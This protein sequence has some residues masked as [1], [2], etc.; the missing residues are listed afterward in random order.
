MTGSE[1]PQRGVRTGSGHGSAPG[2]GTPVPTDDGAAVALLLSVVGLLGCLPVGAAGLAM[3]YLARARIREA[4]G[5]LGGGRM[6]Q[7][8]VVIGW[9]AIGVSVVALVVLLVALA[10]TG[11]G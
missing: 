7:A 9:V 4:D 5:A 10:V 8:A 2:D 11:G 6:A 1:P 3:G